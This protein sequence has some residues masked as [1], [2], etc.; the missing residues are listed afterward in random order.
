[1][2][3][4]DIYAECHINS[5]TCK[6]APVAEHE[7]LLAFTN[8]CGAVSFVEWLEDEGFSLYRSYVEK[9]IDR[10]ESEAW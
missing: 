3:A 10:L 8:D 9:N 1:M 2:S 6:G 4:V 5:Q 7:V